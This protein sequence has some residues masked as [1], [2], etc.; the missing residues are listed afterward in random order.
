MKNTLIF[1]TTFILIFLIGIPIYIR[2]NKCEKCDQNYDNILKI[3]KGMKY[4]QVLSII[5]TP[6]R[7]DT[8]PSHYKDSIFNTYY[9]TPAGMSDNIGLGISMKD[10]TVIYIS[11]GE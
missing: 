7:I 4:K 6:N 1:L 11:K 2:I 5:G 8:I 9:E 3:S 10:S